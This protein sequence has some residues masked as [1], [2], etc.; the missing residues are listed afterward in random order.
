MSLYSLLRN[1]S[2]PTIKQIELSL[3]GNLCRCTGYRSIL[4][5]AI[6]LSDEYNHDLNDNINDT[7]NNT[8]IYGNG[9]GNYQCKWFAS[10]PIR[11]VASIGGNIMTGSPISD[12][13]PIWQSLNA[14]LNLLNIKT[15]EIRNI[16]IRD[17]YIGYRKLNI[18]PTEIL[19]NVIIP[20]IVTDNNIYCKAF[21]QSK[22]KEDDIAI[23]NSCMT[24]K[25]NNN[26]IIED[27]SISFGGMSFMVIYLNYLNEYLIGKNFIE[28][29]NLILEN[30]IK[31][32]NEKLNLN[33]NTPGGQSLYRMTLSQK[34]ESIQSEYH[35]LP[36]IDKYEF[37]QY[38]QDLKLKSNIIDLNLVKELN[39]IGKNHVD[40]YGKKSVE[41]K[42]QYLDDIPHLENELQAYPIFTTQP[43]AKIIEIDESKALEM[44]GV[45]YFVNYKDVPNN[46]IGIVIPNEEEVFKSSE[47]TS[48][49][50]LIGLILANTL[51][52]AREASKKVIIKYQPFENSK[53][54]L[55]IDD[56]INS[57]SFFNDQYRHL[58]SSNI[59]FSEFK[60]MIKN[61]KI[62]N[63]YEYIEGDCYIG[64]QEHFY[65]ETQSCLVIPESNNFIEK[66]GW[67][68]YSSTQSISTTQQLVSKALNLSMNQIQVKTP[69]KI[70]GGF[71]GKETRAS[72]LACACA[73][74]ALK[75][76]QTV[77]LW[78]VIFNRTIKL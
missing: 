19:L 7:N 50:Q 58:Q 63:E 4:D 10:T 23:V 70:G 18:L 36:K 37:G 26:N 13:V 14:K 68:I 33:E 25:L 42:S 60:E 65:L 75:S 51:N 73:I 17:L 49:G 27:C 5:M 64:G 41:G 29:Y 78:N 59:S 74:G 57:N 54:I 30:S 28:N 62:E 40:I 76:Q 32:L 48:C 15:N 52:Q 46:N 77:R 16:S 12:L 22:R 47:S 55:N 61:T 72:V 35:Y 24:I 67:T 43:Y 66:S 31:L 56:A 1:Y 11:N 39:T 34:E 20:N 6:S 69:Q 21:K 9:C 8:S 3:D 45:K 38:I 71:G 2:K 44:E 53:P